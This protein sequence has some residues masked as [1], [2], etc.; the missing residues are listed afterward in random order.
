MRHFRRIFLSY[1]S[2]VES[3]FYAYFMSLCQISERIHKYDNFRTVRDMHT[4]QII[5]NTCTSNQ[6]LCIASYSFYGMRI[7]KF[8]F[9]SVRLF[10]SREI[11]YKILIYK[12]VSIKSLFWIKMHV[13][14]DIS[15]QRYNLHFPADN[16]NEIIISI[17]LY[18]DMPN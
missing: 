6:I 12:N 17:Y 9:I 2:V 13:W 16:S 4:T 18:F 7:V 3:L 1:F 14:C 11:F 8:R 5:T 10:D 15:Y